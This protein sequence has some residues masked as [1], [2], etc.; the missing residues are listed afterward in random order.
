M[1]EGLRGTT[2][3]A[4]HRRLAT[5]DLGDVAILNDDDASIRPEATL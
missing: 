2:S 1:G 4:S 3:A 5:Q